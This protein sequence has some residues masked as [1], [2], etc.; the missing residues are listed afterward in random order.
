MLA[1]LVARY[2]G[3]KKYAHVPCYELKLITLQLVKPAH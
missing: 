1:G 2:P 3:M